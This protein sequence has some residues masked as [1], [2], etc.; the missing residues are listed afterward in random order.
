MINDD[1][2]MMTV[3][4]KLRKKKQTRKRTT[5]MMIMVLLMLRRKRRRG[6]QPV[7]NEEFAWTVL[8][9]VGHGGS[10]DRKRGWVVHW[11]FRRVMRPKARLGCALAIPAGHKI[12]SETVFPQSTAVRRNRPN[13]CI[14]YIYIG[15]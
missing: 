11:P 9:E 10:R 7:G 5:T 13:I 2:T 1:T 4:M 14:I 8:N 12:E 6:L 15:L 3:T